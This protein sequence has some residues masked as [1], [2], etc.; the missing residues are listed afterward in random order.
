MKSATFTFRWPTFE[1]L[2]ELLQGVAPRPIIVTE[3]TVGDI[4]YKFMTDS[5]AHFVVTDSSYKEQSK[6]PLTKEGYKEA[7]A[8]FARRLSLHNIQIVD[9]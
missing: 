7:K 2:C 9:Y 6:Y 5:Q 3:C 1:S 4:R 8:E